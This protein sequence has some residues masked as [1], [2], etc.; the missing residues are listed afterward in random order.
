MEGANRLGDCIKMGREEPNGRDSGK[1][2]WE[3]W[4]EPMKVEAIEAITDI[5]A[6]ES[7]Q[8]MDHRSDIAETDAGHQRFR[9]LWI[10]AF[11]SYSPQLRCYLRGLVRR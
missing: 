1:R 2:R 3:M 7:E 6:R 5:L 9:P 4:K 8:L 10:L 11:S